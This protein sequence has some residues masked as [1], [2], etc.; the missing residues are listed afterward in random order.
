MPAT[1]RYQLILESATRGEAELRRFEQS[2]NRLAD[3]AERSQNRTAASYGRTSKQVSDALKKTGDDAQQFG[4]RIQD[5]ISRPLASASNAFQEFAARGGRGAAVLGGVVLGAAG[6]ATAIGAFVSTAAQGAREISNFADSTGFTLNQMDRFRA[7]AKLSNFELTNLN[8]AAVD[9]SLALRDTGGQGENTRRS[10]REL[11]ISFSDSTGKVRPLNAILLETIEAVSKID[12]TSQR[13]RLSTVLGGEDAA[14][15]IQT[16]IKNYQSANKLAGELGFGT[17]ENVIN[18]LN[19]AATE[20]KKLNLQLEILQGKLAVP[21]TF[22]LRQV[23]EVLEAK[24][25]GTFANVF[26]AALRFSNPLGAG[27][28]AIGS[29][30]AGK[31]A[32]TTLPATRRPLVGAQSADQ[33]QAG[34]ADVQGG[35]PLFSRFSAGRSGE[36]SIQ[37]RLARIQE[38]RSKLLNT[39]GQGTLSAT[40]FNDTLAGINRLTAEERR[41]QEAT[42]NLAAQIAFE[43]KFPQFSAATLDTRTDG[44]LDFIEKRGAAIRSARDSGASPAQV[45]RVS[46]LFGRVEQAN[47]REVVN[48][49]LSEF[50]NR[51]SA[52]LN[53]RLAQFT[54]P[55]AFVASTEDMARANAARDS[56]LANEYALVLQNEQQQRQRILAVTEQELS[57]LTRKVEL[58][59]GPG[60]ER[61]AIEEIAKLKLAALEEEAARSLENFNLGDRRNQIE[62]ERVLALL[63]LERRRRQES[64]EAIGSTFDALISRGSG[65]VGA[66]VRSVGLSQLRTV[67]Q[68]AGEGLARNAGG[69]LGRVG[70]ASGLGRLLTGTLFDPQNADPLKNATDANTVATQQNTAALLSVGA[71][72]G[73]GAVGAIAGLLPGLGPDLAKLS[74]VAAGNRNLSVAG[75]IGG[76]SFGTS[77]LNQAANSA[78][79]TRNLNTAALLSGI[80]L[81][82]SNRGGMTLG[83]GVGMVG[84]GLAGTLGAINGFKAGGAQGVLTGSGAIAGAAASIIALSGATGPAAPILAGIGLALSATAALLGNPKE[85]RDRALDRIVNDARYTDT[86]PLDFTLSTGGGLLDYNKRGELR[87]QPIMLTVNAL[88]A[89]SILDRRDDL[90][91]AVQYAMYEGHSVNRAAQEV[92]L[93][94]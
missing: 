20:T 9:L 68:N 65:G 39:L 17:R 43:K 32:L 1:D 80:P 37:F 7:V 69:F 60:G 66:L 94:V 12:E 47:Q 79:G 41:L 54:V 70:Q 86:A 49:Q 77:S 88:D 57:F 82:T 56:A 25:K 4:Q 21:F 50:S 81:N 11:G 23:N 83:Q 18:T 64:R 53:E 52:G 8:Q 5:F 61:A 93:G 2:I 62:R 44:L 67:A 71:G 6:A 24:P 30:A 63:E 45:A 31:T 3:V 28:A 40:A 48:A 19:E 75:L 90:A 14:A 38:E 87:A 91:T 51:R 78:A 10:L 29:A 74:T 55:G 34:L 13:V 26:D 16:L 72:A 85:R 73:G 27:G 15:R 59:A 46:A 89:K 22:V 76:V 36:Q 84:A 33:L 58:L 35:I 42:A 92:V